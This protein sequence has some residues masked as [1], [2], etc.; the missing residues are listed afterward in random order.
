[1]AV[2]ANLAVEDYLL[3]G[4]VDLAE[5]PLFGGQVG[6]VCTERLL[7]DEIRE[8][9]GRQVP[10]LDCRPLAGLSLL[11]HLLPHHLF[12]LSGF[13]VKKLGEEIN[14]V[15]EVFELVVELGKFPPRA[16][17]LSPRDHR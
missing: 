10:C 1:M 12:V 9:G 17:R 11:E 13:A 14:L 2:V 15:V 7:D 8:R 16:L 4:F 6:P 3:V 5:Q